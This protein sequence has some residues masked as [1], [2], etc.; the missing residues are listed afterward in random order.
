MMGVTEM[1]GK[2]PF[3]PGPNWQPLN[4]NNRWSSETSKYR[5]TVEAPCGWLGHWSKCVK[6]KVMGYI[7]KI[8]ALKAKNG[9][10]AISNDCL[11]SIRLSLALS[12]NIMWTIIEAL[13]M[14]LTNE[15]DWNVTFYRKNVRKTPFKLANRTLNSWEWMRL[16]FTFVSKRGENETETLHIFLKKRRKNMIKEFGYGIWRQ[17]LSTA[18]WLAV[19]ILRPIISNKE[20]Y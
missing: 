2:G 17:W 16:R 19:H 1:S 11:F 15:T 7:T 10:V 9:L 6:E 13:K 8:K 18:T 14:Y 5:F 3:M 4:Q 12:I 20:I